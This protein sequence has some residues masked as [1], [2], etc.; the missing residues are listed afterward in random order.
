VDPGNLEISK[1]NPT[2]NAELLDKKENMSSFLADI[3]FRIPVYSTSS[4]TK[5]VPPPVYT[6]RTYEQRKKNACRQKQRNL[7]DRPLYIPKVLLEL[8]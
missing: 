7:V 6:Q 2:S 3:P 1:D 5:E 4:E 8:N